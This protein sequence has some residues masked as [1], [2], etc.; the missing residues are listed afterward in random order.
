MSPT[1]SVE[2]ANSPPEIRGWKPGVGSPHH[3][4]PQLDT[5]VCPD[6]GPSEDGSVRQG[7]PRAPSRTSPPPGRHWRSRGK[8][9]W[10]PVPPCPLPQPRARRRDTTDATAARGLAVQCSLFLTKPSGGCPGP[11]RR[12]TGKRTL[13]TGE[14]AAEAAALRSPGTRSPESAQAPYLR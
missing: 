13:S 9:G 6:T 7:S 8:D 12:N 2:E 5:L 3:G 10:T 11:C 1:Q 4:A 14:A